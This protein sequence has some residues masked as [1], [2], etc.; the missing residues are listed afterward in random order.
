MKVSIIQPSDLDSSLAATWR[1]LQNS[2]S[3]LANPCF[4]PEFTRLTARGRDQDLVGIVEEGGLP[5]AFFPFRRQ[6]HGI[7]GPLG[8]ILSDFQG[9]I[10]GPDFLCDPKLL[11]RGCGL[12]IW[13]FDRLIAGQQIFGPFHAKYD[14][15]PVISLAMGYESYVQERRHA[16]TEQI[17]KCGNLLRRLE[18]EVGPVSFV[19]QSRDQQ[20]LWKVLGW[21]SQQYVRSGWDDLFAHSWARDLVER[22]FE[23]ASENFVGTFSA[24]YAGERLVAGH[25]GFRSKTVWHYWFPAYDPELA[26]YS[27]GLLLLLKMAEHAP[28]IGIHR[29]DMGKGLSLYK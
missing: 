27:T 1:V 14:S 6:F 26:R 2:N 24:L 23:M 17:K 12:Q 18:L 5:R 16:G 15:A 19:A 29:I 8:G 4:S 10:C 25:F 22:V 7:G 28:K 13:D 3:E 9:I 11:L 21:K 20:A